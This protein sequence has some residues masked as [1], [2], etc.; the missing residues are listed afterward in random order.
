MPEVVPGAQSAGWRDAL[1]LGGPRPLER[2]VAVIR[3]MEERADALRQRLPVHAVVVCGGDARRLAVPHVRG[4][5]R[6]RGVGQRAAKERA[7]AQR[8]LL[9][10]LR[11]H[12]V[13]LRDEHLC[14]RRGPQVPGGEG[15]HGR[16]VDL[17]DRRAEG[18]RRSRQVL[19]RLGPAQ[20]ADGPPRALAAAD[21]L[22]GIVR[23]PR[24]RRTLSVSDATDLRGTSA[25]VAPRRRRDPS[26]WMP[27]RH[28]APRYASSS[29]SW[30]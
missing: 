18:L 3:R 13:V 20:A 15:T 7:S 8:G 24:P 17:S 28:S 5:G 26:L 22:S 1:G 14:R 23:T 27:A 10:D 16:P 9:R 25:S 4:H 12:W 19:V 11:H 6:A 30:P 2:V 29:S 21:L